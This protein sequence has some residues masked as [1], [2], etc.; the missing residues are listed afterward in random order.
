M[1]NAGNIET[2]VFDMKIL[3]WDFCAAI[4]LW[5]TASQDSDYHGKTLFL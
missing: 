5:P 1:R 2:D 4:I 3:I